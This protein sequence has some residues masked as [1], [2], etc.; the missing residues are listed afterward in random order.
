MDSGTTRNTGA[1]RR[2]VA[3]AGGA[4]LALGGFGA[5]VASASSL[6]G[7][8]SAGTGADVTTV[9]GCDHDGVDITYGSAFDVSTGRSVVV[10]VTVD[11]ID[12]SCLGKTI[13]VILSG[14]S[15]TALATATDTVTGTAQ[16]LRLPVPADTSVVVGATVVMTG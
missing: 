13:D 3:L 8:G 4:V 12:A 10:K 6:G 11:G 7:S 16:T 2:F 15:G 9:A 1:W 5:A 14:S